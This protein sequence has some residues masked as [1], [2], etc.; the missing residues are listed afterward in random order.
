LLG[1][2]SADS[3]TSRQAST[4]SHRP[5][6]TAAAPRIESLRWLAAEP[7]ST[8]WSHSTELTCGASCAPPRRSSATRRQGCGAGGVRTSGEEAVE[9]QGRGRTRG[10]GV[11]DRDQRGRR[12]ATRPCART[13]VGLGE[14]DNDGVDERCSRARRNGTRLGG[15]PPYPSASASW[16]F[17]A[18]SRIS[19]GALRL[20]KRAEKALDLLQSRRRSTCTRAL[21]SCHSRSEGQHAR[22]L[23]VV[24]Q[25]N[26]PSVEPTSI[27]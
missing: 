26:G 21:E 9:L 10:V 11:A 14:R 15:L 8:R 25:A 27:P 17:S 12:A 7:R 22:E 20:L 3:L 13:R 19:T 6:N 4:I 2:T 23:L 1:P 16:S 18:T 5:L 24:H